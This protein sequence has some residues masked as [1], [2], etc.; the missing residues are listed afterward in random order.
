MGGWLFS[1]FFYIGLASFTTCKIHGVENPLLAFTE[2]TIQMEKRFT[3]IQIEFEDT[4]ADDIKM[5]WIR[6]LLTDKAVLTAYSTLLESQLPEKIRSKNKLLQGQISTFLESLIG[7]FASSDW[8]I[9]FREKNPDYVDALQGFLLHC[10]SQESTVAAVLADMRLSSLC[11]PP[12]SGLPT[13]RGSTSPLRRATPGSVSRAASCLSLPRLTPVGL[14]PIVAAQEARPENPDPPENPYVVVMGTPLNSS[15]LDEVAL[16]V[17]LAVPPIEPAPPVPPRQRQFLRDAEWLNEGTRDDEVVE[18]SYEPWMEW[19][20]DSSPEREP[21][22]GS[23]GV[24]Y[25][26]TATTYYLLA[27]PYGASA[28]DPSVSLRDAQVGASETD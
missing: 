18:H 14:I 21:I 16:A 11:E 2:L 20:L 19:P 4:P 15:V 22:Y 17:E 24:R 12:D 1:L 23:A 6:Q 9:T 28:S 8:M 13:S 27:G 25:L 3:C 7:S 26:S 5:T 10:Q